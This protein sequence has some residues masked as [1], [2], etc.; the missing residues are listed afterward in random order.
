M[1][2]RNPRIWL[3]VEDDDNDVFL[4]E[5][6]LR[7]ADPNARLQ[8][9]RDGGEA[10]DYLLGHN[11]FADRSLY[12]LPFVILSDLKMPRCSGLELVQ[13]VRTRSEFRTT[14]FIMFSS[15]DQ[16]T[17]IALAY[18]DGANWYLAKPSTFEQLVEMLARLSENLSVSVWNTGAQPKE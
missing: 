16:P 4:M 6:A 17:D 12:P 9:A 8:R 2:A 5:R 11:R 10:K 18:Q 13:W 1:K 3:L 14:P 15:S 7:R